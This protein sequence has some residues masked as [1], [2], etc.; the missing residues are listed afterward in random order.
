MSSIPDTRATRQMDKY[1]AEKSYHHY[2]L[3]LQSVHDGSFDNFKELNRLALLCNC[4]YRTLDQAIGGSLREQL[5]M[6]TGADPC[7]GMTP[8]IYN[9]ALEV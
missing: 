3:S 6:I 7:S 9:L 8:L 1:E 5:Y 4:G 2:E